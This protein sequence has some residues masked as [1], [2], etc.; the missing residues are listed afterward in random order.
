MT[1]TTVAEGNKYPRI[2]RTILTPIIHKINITIFST[3]SMCRANDL[4]ID[5]TLDLFHKIVA[6]CTL[7]GAEIY[8][9]KNCNKLEVLQ[10]K[11]LRYA[12]KF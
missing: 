2:R 5:L 12:L 9:H 7:Y 1:L 6:P 11:Y 8:G 3:L 4:P 10:H